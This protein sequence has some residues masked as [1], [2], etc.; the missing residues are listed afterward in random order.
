[1]TLKFIIKGKN[2]E[3]NIQISDSKINQ[4]RELNSQEA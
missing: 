2:L 1:M 4:N 3:L